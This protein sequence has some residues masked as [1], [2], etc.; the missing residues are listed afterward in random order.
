MART[1]DERKRRTRE[2]VIADLSHNFVERFIL[3]EGHVV[4]R[5]EMDYG[6]D[7]W[8]QPFDEDGHAEVG[9]AYWQL[10]ASDSI[11]L[12]GGTA[13]FD[14]DVRD[15]NQWR[16]ERQPVLLVL[17]DAPRRRAYWL[18]IQGHFSDPSARHPRP[19]ARTVRV[20]IPEGQRLGRRAIR[21]IRRLIQEATRRYDWGGRSMT[22]IT[23]ADLDGV[24]RS[25]GFLSRE[26]EPDTRVYKHPD[27]GAL[28][29]M[30]I[31]PGGD[32]VLTRHYV[33]ARMVL[34]GFGIATPREFE[35]RFQRASPA[36]PA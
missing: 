7:L 20:N 15:Y 5:M 8:M 35:S 36:S 16:R 13:A 18:H 21:R 25:F 19:G 23:Y 3:E 30:P 26:P 10:K 2:H 1:H 28:V 4:Q 11:T 31:H 33:G 29:I 17:F 6:F 12:V 32:E 24:L 14:L 34:E 22:G 9:L 27:T